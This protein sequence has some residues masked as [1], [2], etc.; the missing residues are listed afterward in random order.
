MAKGDIVLVSF[1][2]TDLTGSKLRPAVILTETALD[3]TACFI[4]TQIRWQ[5]ATDI[6]L[7]PKPTNSLK[8]LSLLRTSKIATLDK[9]L[10]RGLLGRLSQTELLELNIKLKVLFQIP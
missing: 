6:L 4:T 9:I 5:E 3:I 2:F 10:V 1:P 8:R 7:T